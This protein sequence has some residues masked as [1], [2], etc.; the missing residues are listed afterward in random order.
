MIYHCIPAGLHRILNLKESNEKDGDDTSVVVFGEDW[1][2]VELKGQEI[3]GAS[4]FQL[5]QPQ[6]HLPPFH[7][8]VSLHKLLSRTH[9]IATL[10]QIPQDENRFVP[11]LILRAFSSHCCVGLANCMIII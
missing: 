6:M 7:P 11:D 4:I 9:F 10:L 3:S 8:L 2:G 1:K 5:H